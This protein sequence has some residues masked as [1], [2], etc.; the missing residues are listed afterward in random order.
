MLGTGVFTPSPFIP[1]HPWWACKRK[2][3]AWGP[4]YPSGSVGE[5][6]PCGGRGS[7]REGWGRLWGVS[8]ELGGSLDRVGTLPVGRG[9]GQEKNQRG[10]NLGI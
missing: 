5:G 7:L 10:E 4:E 1:H 3:M 9:A 6:L 2:G 8:D